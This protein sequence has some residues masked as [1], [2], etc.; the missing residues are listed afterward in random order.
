MIASKVVARPP[1]AQT[2]S[3]ETATI[4]ITDA[5]GLGRLSEWQQPLALKPL[6]ADAEATGKRVAC[7]RFETP[8]VPH[9]LLL[10]GRKP[11]GHTRDVSTD[12]ALAIATKVSVRLR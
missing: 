5:L 3:E 10:R 4:Q 7:A 11:I 6:V 2:G 9:S 8:K 1:P 12:A